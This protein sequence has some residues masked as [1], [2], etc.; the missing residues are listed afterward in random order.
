MITRGP[1]TFVSCWADIS[2]SWKIVWFVLV[3]THK[4]GEFF[5][6]APKLSGAATG[7]FRHFW[8]CTCLCA[9]VQKYER[10]WFLISGRPR[11]SGTCAGRGVSVVALCWFVCHASHL[12]YR[13]LHCTKQCVCVFLCSGVTKPSLLV[14]SSIPF[15]LSYL[16]H[17]F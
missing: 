7:R 5:F 8:G 11:S 15:S 3:A 16:L 14:F 17:F 6:W 12:L 10:R 4:G 9:G 1:T 2:L 13:F